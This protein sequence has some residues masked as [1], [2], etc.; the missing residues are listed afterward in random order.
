MFG[1]RPFLTMLGS[2]GLYSLNFCQQ[3]CLIWSKPGK[4]VTLNDH[5]LWRF[6]LHQEVP[7]KA[8]NHLL[9]INQ[10]NNARRPTGDSSGRC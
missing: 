5:H 3:C 8:I 4:V 1:V 7:R 2:L 6:L 9:H 10:L